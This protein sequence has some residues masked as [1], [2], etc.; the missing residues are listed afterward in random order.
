MRDTIYIKM[1]KDE[2]KSAPDDMKKDQEETWIDTSKI[3][4]SNSN[5]EINQRESIKTEFPDVLKA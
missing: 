4:T 1:D 5:T 3:S 2:K